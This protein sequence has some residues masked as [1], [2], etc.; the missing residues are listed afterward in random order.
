MAE[1]ETQTSAHHL[2]HQPTPSSRSI[3]MALSGE[4]GRAP[5]ET[6]EASGC[7]DITPSM[8]LDPIALTYNASKSYL[9]PNIKF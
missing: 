9:P 6:D 3:E 4:L 2:R 5:I 1:L 7:S 8:L